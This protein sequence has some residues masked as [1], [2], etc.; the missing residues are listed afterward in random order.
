MGSLIDTLVSFFHQRLA[1]TSS[2]SYV[3]MSNAFSMMSMGTKNLG[4]NFV[5]GVLEPMYRSFRANY[6]PRNRP[7]NP[8]VGS[9]LLKF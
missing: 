4:M 3:P 7:N 5:D 9:I 6:P 2:H 1:K 8:E